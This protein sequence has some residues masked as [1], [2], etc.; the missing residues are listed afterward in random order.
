MFS[1]EG[2][3]EVNKTKKRSQITVFWTYLSG[4]VSFQL[5]SDRIELIIVHFLDLS[6]S[7]SH[8]VFPVVSFWGSV[9]VGK[10]SQFLH[11]LK[12]R[13]LFVNINYQLQGMGFNNLALTCSWIDLR[14]SISSCSVWH[15][16][17]AWMCSRVSLSRSFG[18]G[19]KFDLLLKF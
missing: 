7:L 18:I 16:F 5:G 12:L 11:F 10:S 4:V 13:I 2:I 15:L 1:I 17:S 6:Q 19:K 8:F 9:A 14:K 3:G